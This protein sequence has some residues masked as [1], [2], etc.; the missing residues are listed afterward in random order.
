MA[1]LFYEPHVRRACNL[2]WTV[3]K[4]FAFT[5]VELL[6]VIAIIGILVAL[7]LPA[8]QQ[9]REAARR[10]QCMNHLKEIGTGFLLHEGSHKFLPTS[11]YGPW[12]V[13]DAMRGRGKKQPG[14][15]MYNILPF[16]EEQDL[17]NLTNDGDPKV[18]SQ[19]KTAAVK[20]QQTPVTIYN[21][22]TRRPPAARPY[23]LG[24][25]WQPLNSDVIT[26][27]VRGD[28]AANGGDGEGGIKFPQR[29]ADGK[30]TGY[31]PILTKGG[32]ATLDNPVLFKFPGEKDQSGINFLGAEISIKEITDGTSHVYMVG[33][34]YMNSDFYE[35]ESTGD[36]GDG[37][38]NHSCY[39]GFDWDVI[40]WATDVWRAEQDRPGFDAF[41]SFGSAHAGVWQAVFCDGSV[42]TLPYDLDNVTH[43]RL[44]NR[45]DG[46][47]V[48][49]VP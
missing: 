17:Y 11:G 15:W 9:A 7:L 21:C 25:G 45:F 19:Q 5:L 26:A 1:R 29:D 32:Y 34:K 4:R 2:R 33:E 16:I 6:V 14:G 3:R 27:V 38:D 35:L 41:Q 24:S 36:G 12:H 49:A 8:I 47:P 18:T 43:M 39:S 20:M 23:T 30:I 37:G 31:Q 13:G 44:A 28:Y 40:R 10:A 48:A 46:E 42:H 22:P